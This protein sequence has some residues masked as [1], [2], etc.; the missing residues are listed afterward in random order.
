MGHSS[1]FR[2]A[3]LACV[4]LLSVA[5]GAPRPAVETSTPLPVSPVA[6]SPAATVAPATSTPVPMPPTLTVAVLPAGPTFTPQPSPAAVTSTPSPL[7]PGPSPTASQPAFRIAYFTVAPTNTL[8]AGDPLSIAWDASGE[9]ASLCFIAAPGPTGCRDVPLTGSTTVTVTEE[10]LT[11]TGVGLRV[12]AGGAFTWSIV[13]LQFEC[14]A[15]DWF[16][17]NH[18]THCP[19]EAP[20]SAHAAAQYF[21]HG[22]MV[23]TETPDRFYVFFVEGNEYVFADAPYDFVTAEPVNATPPPGYYEPVSGFGKVWRGELR[24]FETVDVR[25]RL[26]WATAPEF[27]FDTVQQCDRHGRLWSCYLRGP[28]GGVLWLHPDSSAQVRFLWERLKP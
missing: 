25:G 2:R 26:G 17:E 12:S 28:D 19:Q 21:E 27:A 14:G 16:F 24:A 5:C 22:T 9:Q 3:C 20:T 10:M 23:W 4:L 1:R 11:D 8:A 7:A 18:P 6:P 15:R 13:D